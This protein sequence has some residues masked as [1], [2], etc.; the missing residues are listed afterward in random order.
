M[1]RVY[2]ELGLGNGTLCSTEFEEND[3]ET[4]VPSFIRP[5]VV[6]E[7][8]IRIWIGKRVFIFS[9][10]NGFKTYLKGK[11]KFKALVGLAG[12]EE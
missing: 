8:Y 2:A 10:K 3:S 1:K 12:N 11:N 4:R 5:K 7:Y 9:T 6:D